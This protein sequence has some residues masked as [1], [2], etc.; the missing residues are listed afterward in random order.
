MSRDELLISL[1]KRAIDYYDG[2]IMGVDKDGIVFFMND[3]GIKKC[4]VSKETIVNHS[5]YD[6]V[7]DKVFSD[8][9]AI[10][11]LKTKKTAM[12]FLKIGKNHD[13]EVMAISKPFL[14]ENGN[15]EMIIVYSQEVPFVQEYLDAIKLERENTK[16][17][18]NYIEAAYKREIPP[19]VESPVSK[20]VFSY[21]KKVAK[22]D[23][24]VMLYGESGTGKEVMARYIHKVSKRA[25]Q[26]FIPVNCA[27]IPAEL[28]ESEFFGYEKGAFTGAKKEG[29]SGVFELANNG[30]LFLDEL[31]ELPIGLQA[32]LLRVIEYG[33]VQRLGSEKIV[34]IDARIIAATNRDLKKMVQEGK[35]R[36]D[37]FYRLNVIPITIPPIKERREDIIPLAQSFLDRY[38]KK[39]RLAKYF[40]KDC[41]IA[42]EN[43]NWP[44]NV[45]ELKNLVER[46][47]IITTSDAIDINNIVGSINPSEVKKDNQKHIVIYESKSLKDAIKEF[48]MKCIYQVLEECN[49]DTELAAKRLKINRASLYRKLSE[50]KN[51][52]LKEKVEQS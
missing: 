13:Q 30:T 16:E 21:A 49:K 15:I 8:A 43:Y 42:M 46:M 33:E 52:A 22:V 51:L 27:A 31:G 14:D 44:G 40:T 10:E 32:K 37:L 6:L 48:E 23:S 11:A 35:F 24:I 25:E 45:R 9:S 7:K 28:M 36:E 47:V 38:N 2:S 39:Y 18:I 34:Q 41:K 5:I 19:V 29:K 50:Y 3:I 12:K 26:I 1:Y 4:E 20:S 17:L